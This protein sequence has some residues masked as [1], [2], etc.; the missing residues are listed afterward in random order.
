MC[1]FH[2][3]AQPFVNVML[4]T[5]IPNYK[6]QMPSALFKPDVFLPPNLSN[7]VW[8]FDYLFVYQCFQFT[9]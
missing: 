6:K 4:L 1:A 9:D 7:E 3:F 5:S 8:T 2:L